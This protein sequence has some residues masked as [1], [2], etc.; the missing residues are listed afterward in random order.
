M[1]ASTIGNNISTIEAQLILDDLA[2]K[3]AMGEANVLPSPTPY[4]WLEV[5]TK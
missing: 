5:N 2:S 1:G 3:I 4:L